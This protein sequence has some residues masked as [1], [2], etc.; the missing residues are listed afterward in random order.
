MGKVLISL[1]ATAT[2]VLLIVLVV[3]MLTHQGAV[4]GSVTP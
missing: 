4:S 2:A 1:A 3:V